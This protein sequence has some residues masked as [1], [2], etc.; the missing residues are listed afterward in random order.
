MKCS[1]I[2]LF[3]TTIIIENKF[4][5]PYNIPYDMEDPNFTYNMVK[6]D[7]DS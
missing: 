1:L 3:N 6:V 5:P 2:F 7:I 4:V